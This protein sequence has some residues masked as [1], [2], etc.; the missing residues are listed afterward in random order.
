MQEFIA[1]FDPARECF[2]G[3]RCHITVLPNPGRDEHVSLA[4]ARVEPGVST[5]L[6]RPRGV[7]ERYVLLEG[8][9][10]VEVGSLPP[11]EVRA[12]DVVHIPASVPQRITNTGDGDLVF[13][14]VCTPPFTEECYEDLDP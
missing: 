11:T 3:E 6:H 5:A 10:L 4:R 12:G 14:C 9:G 7:E 2:T 1:G 8:Q 13:L